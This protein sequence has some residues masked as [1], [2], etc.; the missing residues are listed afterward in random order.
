MKS[1]FVLNE[2][3][4]NVHPVGGTI[5]LMTEANVIN[6]SSMDQGLLLGKT[7]LF[8]LFKKSVI[9]RDILLKNNL[10]I[11]PFFLHFPKFMQKMTKMQ[12]R[13]RFLRFP[14]ILSYFSKNRDKISE[15][16]L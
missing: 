7:Q 14:L 5:L 15:K 1:R 3:V 10:H 2:V 12:K 16:F 9:S 11:L 6:I 4:I 8:C 13:G